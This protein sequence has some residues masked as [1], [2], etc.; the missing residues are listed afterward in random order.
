MTTET[1]KPE[2]PV[3]AEWNV[4]TPYCVGDIVI[5]PDGHRIVITA[6][7]SGEELEVK[8]TA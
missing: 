2:E 5:H 4:S 3:I 6:T 8:E 7:V 1:I